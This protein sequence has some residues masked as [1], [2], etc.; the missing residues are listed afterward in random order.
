[1]D[2]R[3]DIP[4]VLFIA[5]CAAARLEG[6]MGCP[7]TG[8]LAALR[9]DDEE[10]LRMA[11]AAGLLERCEA[12]DGTVRYRLTPR[13]MEEERAVRE[14]WEARRRQTAATRR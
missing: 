11:V 4:K 3:Q 14:E 7:N 1:M 10:Y 5:D 6:S 13:A 2:D 9:D 12:E 8:L